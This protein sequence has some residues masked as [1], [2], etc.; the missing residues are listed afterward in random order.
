[1]TDRDRFRDPDEREARATVAELIDASL[2]KLVTAIIV[3]GGLIAIAIWWS[4]SPH[5]QVA[6]GDGLVVRVNTHSGKVIACRGEVC[7]QVLE[8]GQ[9]LED[10]LPPPTPP[11]PALS[12]PAAAP[13]AAPAPAPAAH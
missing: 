2:R 12:A 7:A 3:A 13:A 4:P 8:N 10:H 6:V 5:Y 9:D 11:A 1:M